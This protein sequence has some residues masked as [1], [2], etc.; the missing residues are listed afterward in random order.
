[1]LKNTIQDQFIKGY[2]INRIEHNGEIVSDKLCRKISNTEFEVLDNVRTPNGLLTAS[3]HF[4]NQLNNQIVNP[5][6]CICSLSEVLPVI[7]GNVFE[8][9]RLRERKIEQHIKWCQC[10]EREDN[11]FQPD[12]HVVKWKKPK[13]VIYA[14]VDGDKLT[15]IDGDLLDDQLKEKAVQIKYP[16]LLRTAL[17]D[18]LL[19]EYEPAYLREVKKYKDI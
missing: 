13:R 9:Y 12:K 18:E 6:L 15:E 14:I 8:L 10:V 3:E 4:L 16:K 1:M 7:N 11:Q 19:N 17:K 5:E 2:F